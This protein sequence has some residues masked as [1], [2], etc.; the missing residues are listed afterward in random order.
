MPRPPAAARVLPA[1]AL[2]AAALLTASAC[3]SGGAPDAA[4]ATEAQASR[5]A[6]PASPTG[7]AM[8]TAAQAQAALL[9]ETDLG[10]P[11]EPTEG[12]A[13]W[14]DG[15]LKGHT[16]T[17]GCA[18]LMDSLYADEP[19][20]TPTGTRA[21]VAYDDADDQAQLRY[22]V[23]SLRAADVD[24]SLSW[25]RTLPRSCAQFTTETTAAGTQDVQVSEL[26][27]PEVGDARQGLR[28]T[29]TG[30]SDDGDATTLTLDVVAVRV[31][32]DAIVLTDGALG[33][34]PPDTTTRAVKLGVQR[35]T[36]A[37]QKARAQA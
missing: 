5:P 13:T 36:E 31:G 4:S 9:T 20:G 7:A 19:L 8:L 16:D 25:L 1:A 23:L 27:L 35:L 22:Q 18:R 34:L 29:F 37:R 30:A 21:V 14:R 3:S 32:D 12:A 11:W 33:A 26:A 2:C 17:A 28:V 15:V 6:A 24:R 10:A